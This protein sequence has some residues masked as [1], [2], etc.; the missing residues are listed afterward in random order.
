MRDLI[1]DTTTLVNVS[2]SGESNGFCSHPSI[3][4]DGSKVA[5]VSDDSDLVSGDTN[6]AGEVFV[7]D[8]TTSTTTGASV[9]SSG[10]QGNYFSQFRWLPASAAM[11]ARWRFIL[12]PPI[13]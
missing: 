10:E 9:S 1:T 12:V 4:A 6:N 2:S 3:S 11:A 5:F 8:L 7:R 13:W